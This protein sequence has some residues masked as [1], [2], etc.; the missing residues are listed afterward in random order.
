[1]E[2]ILLTFGLGE[3]MYIRIKSEKIAISIFIIFNNN[4]VRNCI[5]YS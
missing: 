2:E 5:N 3:Q 1:M 4:K